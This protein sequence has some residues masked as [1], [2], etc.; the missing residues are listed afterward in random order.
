MSWP[1]PAAVMANTFAVTC[2][3]IVL[4]L[5]MFF[6][7]KGGNNRWAWP[8]TLIVAS[9]A[10]TFFSVAAGKLSGKYDMVRLHADAALFAPTNL[11][12]RISYWKFYSGEILSSTKTA[13][14]SHVA[15]PDR[16]HFPS[17][18]NYYVDFAYNFGVVALLPF[19]AFIGLTV[20]GIVRQWPRLRSSAPH[21]GLAATVLFIIIVDNSFKVGMRQ[22]Y[23]GT[24]TF[25]LWGL[26]LSWLF[27]GR[28]AGNDLRGSGTGRH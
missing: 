9:C 4:G 6:P 12:Q 20:A 10:I 18:H 11:A 25:F 1:F 26:L 7:G 23:P 24:L 3:M 2:M 27:P 8:L 14:P 22:P 28:H 5:A 16:T 15:P 17:A 21:A 19:L 13:A